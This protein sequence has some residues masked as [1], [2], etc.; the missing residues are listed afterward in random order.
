MPLTSLLPPTLASSLQ[1]AYISQATEYAYITLLVVLCVY[2]QTPIP[3]GHQHCVARSHTNHIKA[4]G[5]FSSS[6]GGGGAK[7]HP[8]SRVNKLLQLLL[9]GKE[10]LVASVEGLQRFE[11]RAVVSEEGGAAPD[12]LPVAAAH[13]ACLQ[14]QLTLQRTGPIAVA[15]AVYPACR[16]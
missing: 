3:P 12:W 13:T 11:A 10:S 8:V 1:S 4:S 9:A 6:A 14:L 2:C 16:S 5:G 7:R 15:G